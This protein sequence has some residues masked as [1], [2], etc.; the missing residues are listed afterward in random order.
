MEEVKKMEAKDLFI[1]LK[2][3]ERKRIFRVLT[4]LT[5]LVFMGLTADKIS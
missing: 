1:D 3:R 4:V 2:L 5:G